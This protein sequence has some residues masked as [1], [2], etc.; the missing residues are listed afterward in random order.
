[1]H[2]IRKCFGIENNNQLDNEVEANE[3]YVGCKNKIR[4]ND[5]KAIASQ[6]RSTK[7][8][9]P[10]V[11]MVER[12]GKLNVIVVKNLGSA[13]LA[14]KIVANVKGSESLYTGEWLGYKGVS[15]IYDHSE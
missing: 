5:K 7:D 10:V 2:R 13:T 12:K 6:G 11:V 1:M 4:H 15:R 8:K 9:T 14:R 3:T